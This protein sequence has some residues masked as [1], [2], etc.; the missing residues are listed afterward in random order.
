MK[1]TLKAPYDTPDM[2]FDGKR[3]VLT[4]EYA[5]RTFPPN[6]KDD[7]TLVLR[8]QANS[9][10]VYDF[11]HYRGHSKNRKIVDCLI[12]RTEEGRAFIQEVLTAQMEA[13]IKTGYNDLTSSPAINMSNGQIMDREELFRNAISVDTEQILEGSAGIFGVDILSRAPFPVALRWLI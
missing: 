1:I 6:F 13:D 2:T 10:K 4:L 8:L 5:K 11:I 12:N 3:Y 9:R 7:E